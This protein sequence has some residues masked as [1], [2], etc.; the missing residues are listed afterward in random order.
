[1]ASLPGSSPATGSTP[2]SGAAAW[3]SST[4]R[5]TSPS[6]APWRSRCST[7]I[8]PR[9]RRSGGDSSA[10]PSSRRRWI[11]PTS[12]R[13]TPPASAT[14][15]RTSRCASCRGPT[16]R[17]VLRS[18]GRLQPER[19]ARIIAQVAFRARR[20]ARPRPG[21]PGRQARQR[22]RHAG[23]PRVPDGLRAHQARE[24]GT[25][26]PPARA[27][28]SERSTTWRPSRSAAP[29]SGPYTDIYSLGCMTVHLLTGEVP[30][31]VE[32]E[33]AK[34]WAHVSERPPRPSERVPGLGQAFDP[35]V[36]R[37]MAK[38]PEQR[39]ASA[40][41]VGE[42]MLEAVRPPVPAPAPPAA[43][44][45]APA[46]P[47]RPGGPARPRAPWR[48]ARCWSPRCPTASTSACSPGCSSSAPSSGRS[49]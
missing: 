33:E 14:A 38:V 45:P 32:T 19:V 29:R 34:L 10:S 44:T 49:P 21:A 1:M 41:Q 28:C 4:G 27:W 37:A 15:C 2:A 36:A 7:T 42:A 30:F 12:S 3:A 24:P 8:W 47:P 9:T 16:F 43:E 13:S 48:S 35:I 26:K 25:P 18:E 5:P 11:T 46:E 40:G 17:S 31:P 22:P 6:T 23:G 39:Y 20:R